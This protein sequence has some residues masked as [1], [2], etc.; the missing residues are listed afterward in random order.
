MS[1]YT[2]NQPVATDLLEISQPILANNTNAADAFFG[3]NHYSFAST[4]GQNGKHTNIQTPQLAGGHPTT[5][6][7]QPSLYAMQDSTNI[8]VIQYSRGPSDAIP[9][10]ITSLQSPAT[11]ITLA[12]GITTNVLNFAAAPTA[13]SCINAIL[14]FSYNLNA[15][16]QLMQTFSVNWNGTSFYSVDMTTG[17]FATVVNSGTTLQIK[18]PTGAGIS[19]LYW[20]LQLL[21]IQ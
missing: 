9:S 11:P 7:S 16:T 8:G 15:G 5:P 21:R 17:G 19:N 20:T 10:P 4:S 1:V 2:L 14:Y 12:A 3:L 18:A 6:A 13:F